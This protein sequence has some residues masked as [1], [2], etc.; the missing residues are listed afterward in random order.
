M[1]LLCC[2][3]LCFLSCAVLSFFSLVLSRLLL[4]CLVFCCLVSSCLVLSC[5]VLSCTTL[6]VYALREFGPPFSMSERALTWCDCHRIAS[7]PYPSVI[8]PFFLLIAFAKF[9]WIQAPSANSTLLNTL[10]SRRGCVPPLLGT[11]FSHLLLSCCILKE[12]VSPSR[13]GVL[14]R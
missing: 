5:R 6:V 3:I 11:F 1:I 10:A 2:V 12:S 9:C 8:R 14:R 13:G 4:S 7:H